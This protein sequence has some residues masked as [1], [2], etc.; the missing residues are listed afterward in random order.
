MPMWIRAT[1]R[2]GG[3]LVLVALLITLVKQL[4]MLIGFVTAA[5]KII[6]ILVFVAL[7]LSVGFVLLKAW[8]ETRR[9]AE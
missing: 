6:I 9:K 5:I 7:I 4:I 1:G 3:I 2:W 8:N